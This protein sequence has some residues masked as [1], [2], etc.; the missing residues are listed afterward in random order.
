MLYSYPN[1][2]YPRQLVWKSFMCSNH[3]LFFSSNFSLLRDLTNIYTILVGNYPTTN[4]I[5][6]LECSKREFTVFSKIL[7]IL[8]GCMLQHVCVC[9]SGKFLIIAIS[10]R[11]C[12]SKLYVLKLLCQIIACGRDRVSGCGCGSRQSQSANTFENRWNSCIATNRRVF[13]YHHRRLPILKVYT[14]FCS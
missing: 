8:K 2:S 4:T 6:T 12:I 9:V 3:R 10:L 7:F 11:V 13:V 14:Y 1:H 5:K